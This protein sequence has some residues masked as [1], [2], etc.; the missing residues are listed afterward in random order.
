MDYEFEPFNIYKYLTQLGTSSHGHNIMSLLKELIDNSIDA[1]STNIEITH[2]TDNLNKFS[3]IITDNGHG[4]DQNNLYKCVQIAS[5]NTNNGIGKFGI[6]GISA[7]VNLSDI[8]SIDSKS[9]VYIVSKIKK[10]HVCSLEIDWKKCNSYSGYKNQIDKSYQLNKKEDILTMQGISHG[11][12]ITIHT[13]KQKYE[14]IVDIT[15]TM[16]DYIN[17]SQTYSDYLIRG[18]CITIFDDKILD[19]N[20]K[21][22]L[23]TKYNIE[24]WKN[25]NKMAYSTIVNNK[26]LAYTSCKKTQLKEIRYNDLEEDWTYVCKVEYYL[27]IPLGIYNGCLKSPLFKWNGCVSFIEFCNNIAEGI[28]DSEISYLFNDYLKPLNIYRCIST[29]TNMIKRLLGKLSIPYLIQPISNVVR[30]VMVHNVPPY[31]SIYNSI[32]KEL[33]FS[34]EFDDKMGL[35]Q[36]N[37]STVEWTNAPKYLKEFILE[38][39]NKWLG[40]EC[41]NYLD[42]IDK[43]KKEKQAFINILH[44][45]CKKHLEYTKW[46]NNCNKSITIKRGFIYKNPTTLIR[47]GDPIYEETTAIFIQTIY[48]S[49]YTRK[50]YK[51]TMIAKKMQAIWRGYFIRIQNLRVKSSNIIQ[52]WVTSLKI[53]TSEPINGH[54]KFRKFIKW[55]RY[56]YFALQIKSLY[57]TIKYTNAILTIQRC[58]RKFIY[59]TQIYHNSVHIIQRFMK[60]YVNH[61]KY[62]KNKLQLEFVRTVNEVNQMLGVHFRFNKYDSYKKY[63]LE[64]ETINRND[65]CNI[66]LQ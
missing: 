38:L 63:I 56:Y 5:V 26:R 66:S 2:S 58:I 64:L 30:K 3:I 39:T 33:H 42:Q 44:Q 25:K 50:N 18:V 8:T 49:H 62:K 27:S 60:N 54:L 35:V 55:S 7:L 61:I 59:N 46:I 36:Q 37:K 15:N 1:K 57:M 19:I 12:I 24:I 47:V 53:L 40:T 6:G 21:Y 9:S 51:K 29:K 48:R 11:T 14:E 34:S 43:L 52:D 65:S 31:Y 32:Y 17:L 10:G 4:M 45:M 13:S 16:D 23:R 20:M 22:D 28:S 41:R